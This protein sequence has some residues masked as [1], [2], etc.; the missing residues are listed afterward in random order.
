MIIIYVGTYEKRRTF[1]LSLARARSPG[2]SVPRRRTMRSFIFNSHTRPVP[3]VRPPARPPGTGCTVAP[4]GR[5]TIRA[6]GGVAAA[7]RRR[8]GETSAAHRGRRLVQS[9]RCA[10]MLVAW[11]RRRRGRLIAA[12]RAPP[13]PPPT[14]TGHRR[15]ASRR[16]RRLGRVFPNWTL[17]RADECCHTIILLSSVK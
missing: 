6:R 8:P 10:R 13:P 9:E 1:S 5:E 15:S 11:R 7:G 14:T 17:A 4:A 2:R 16:R 12:R 3:P